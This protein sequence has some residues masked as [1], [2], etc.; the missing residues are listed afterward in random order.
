MPHHGRSILTLATHPFGDGTPWCMYLL[1]TVTTNI[2][3]SE[4]SLA[5]RESLGGMISTVVVAGCRV[6]TYDRKVT[7][8]SVQSG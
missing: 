3:L 8:V 7:V 1:V 4:G 6:V 5:F 2:R